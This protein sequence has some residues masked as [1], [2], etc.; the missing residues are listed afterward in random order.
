M[1][2]A[3]HICA[4]L[5]VLFNKE[6]MTRKR[7]GMVG[8]FYENNCGEVVE[9]VEY[10]NSKNVFVKF[11][12]G[13]VFKKGL[14]HLISGKFTSPTTKTV[15][16]IGC[17]GE[18]EY[19]RVNSSKCL[20]RWGMMLGRCYDTSMR[21]KNPSYNNCTVSVEWHNYQNYATWYHK[22]FV[23][24]YEIDKD[25]ISGVV[26]SESNCLF[27]PREINSFFNLNKSRRG[28]CPVGVYKVKGGYASRC[29]EQNTHGTWLGVYQTVEE[30]FL[31]YK[32]VKELYAKALAK[33]FQG[34]LDERVIHKLESFVVSIDD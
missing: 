30:A 18:G 12:D 11:P 16:S 24:D 9:I 27:I 15:Y 4:R 23:D 28:F 25:I 20:A 14:S 32:T 31:A 1:Y 5:V 3:S 19:N 21:A 33:K 7:T 6:V 2:M 13:G 8:T 34:T 10:T 17:M 29:R 22:N 26:Y